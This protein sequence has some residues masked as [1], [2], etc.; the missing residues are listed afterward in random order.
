MVINFVQ[1]NV[2]RKKEAHFS[3]LENCLQKKIDI[4]LLQEPYLPQINGYHIAINHTAFYTIPPKISPNLSKIEK[5]PRVITYIRK[6]AQIQFNPRYD[7]C[8]DSDLQI[9]DILGIPEPFLIYNIYNEKEL[10]AENRLFTI[11]RLLLHQTMDKPTLLVGDF[12]L[13]HT[14]WNPSTEPTRLHKSSNLVKWLKSN[15]ADLIN[16]IDIIN[17]KGG[18]Y[19][20][21]NLK[22]TSIIDLTFVFKFNKTKWLN[23]NYLDHSGSD[24][25]VISFQAFEQNSK[26]INRIRPLPNYKKADWSILTEQWKIES[27]RLLNKISLIRK[28][29]EIDEFIIQLNKSINE[30]MDKSIP[31]LKITDRSKP[32]WSVE[33]TELRKKANSAYRRFKKR[34]TTESEREYKKA[35]NHYFHTLRDKKEEHWLSFLQNASETG[36]GNDIYTAFRYTKDQQSIKIPEIQYSKEGQEKTASLFE[37]KCEAFLETLFPKSNIVQD[38]IDLNLEAIPDSKWEWPELKDEEIEKAIKS[39]N[40][41]KAP[42][43]D[44]IGFILVKRLY[45]ISPILFNSIYRLCFQLGYHPKEWKQSIGIILPKPN[46]EDYSIPKSYRIISLLNCQGKVLEKIYSNRLSYLANKTDL[47]N[48]TQIGGRKQRSAIDAALLLYHHIQDNSRNRKK[49]KSKRSEKTVISTVFLDIKGAFD[50]VNKNRLLQIMIEMRLPTYLI[51]WIDSFLSD[52]KIQLSFDGNRQEMVDIQVGIPQGSPISPILFL[53]YIRE[54]IQDRAFQLSYIDD[55]CISVTSISIKSNCKKLEEII[56]S[57]ISEAEK[58]N[59]LFDMGKTELIHFYDKKRAGIEEP[60]TIMI[61]NIS[62][63]IKPKMLIRWLG[64]WFDSKLSFKDH[65][66]K[67]INLANAALYRLKRLS[68]TQKGLDSTANRRLYIACITSISDFGIQLWWNNRAKKTLL[69]KYQKLQ[70]AAIRQ[71]TGAFKNTPHKALEI[72]AAIPPPEVRFERLCNRYSIRSLVFNNNHPVRS[73][74]NDISDE[75]GNSETASADYT[76]NLRYTRTH[77]QLFKLIKRLNQ[78]KYSRQIEEIN[79][80]RPPWELKPLIDISISPLSKKQQAKEH[81]RLLESLF[82][83]DFLEKA[84]FYTDGSQGEY[85]NKLQ[86]SASLCQIKKKNGQLRINQGRY[87]NLGHE[88]EVIDAEIFAIYKVLQL[89]DEKQPEI[90][91]DEI[92]IFVDSQAAI[93]RIKNRNI[94]H[95]TKKIHEYANRLAIKG[96]KIS[97]QWCPGHEKVFGNEIA[98]KLAKKGLTSLID[99]EAYTSLSF[100]RRK[101]KYIDEENWKKEW[102]STNQGKGVFYESLVKDN[103]QFQRKPAILE[104]PRKNQSAFIQL[105]TQIGYLKSYFFKL[106]RAENIYCFCNR[107]KKQTTFHLIM[108]CRKYNDKR[109]DLRNSLKSEKLPLT[110]QVLFCTKKGKKALADFLI[111]TEICTAKWYTSAGRIEDI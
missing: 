96:Y 54:L 11:D 100:I 26:S 3:V 110:L 102:N 99:I 107:Y 52:R 18:T 48:N 79:T 19:F 74:I 28:E 5:R 31:D 7:I 84:I 81:K 34:Q 15:K 88:I 50:H 55:F 40:E 16:E 62:I 87:W 85:N 65:I 23:W 46:K 80:D 108:E 105:K 44:R 106:G 39:S 51:R 35:R 93:L 69:L 75:L 43:N 67:R 33:L 41:K 109:L 49:R 68:N 47:L 10:G 12:N 70:N 104:M 25:E 76:T 20:R 9:I 4:V 27:K 1:H 91:I 64:I 95:I 37:E 83:E 32:W 90:K 8:N 89:I 103:I 53:I 111:S 17:E 59:I 77:T 60:I 94:N 56:K 57:L 72:E 86:N 66:E 13:H 14:W 21:P 63:I 30:C 2:N 42:G 29:S 36:Y 71:I 98:D 101:A 82:E 58:Q 73:L 45:E 38:D 22:T 24:H 61:D 6:S 78:F 92:Y 97:I